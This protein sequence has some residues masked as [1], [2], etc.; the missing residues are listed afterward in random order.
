[1]NSVIQPSAAAIHR[2]GLFVL[3][4]IKQELISVF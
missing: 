1:M 2:F 3:L 4:L